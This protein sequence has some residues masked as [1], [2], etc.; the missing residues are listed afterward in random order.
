MGFGKNRVQYGDFYWSFFRFDRF[1]TYYYVNGKELAEYTSKFAYKKIEEIE[2]KFEYRLEKRIIFI[3]YNNL[4]DFRQ[5][6]IGLISGD[7]QYN[8]GGVTKINRNKVFIFYEGD[9]KK[10]EDQISSAI[11]EIVLTEMLF[12]NR[13]RDKVANSTLISLPEWYMLGLI[14]YYSKDWNFEIENEIKDAVLAGKFED[15]NHME[16]KDAEIVG[17]SIWHYI[18]KVHGK[19]AIPNIVH[20]T[21]VSKSADSGFLFALG[22]SF[23]DFSYD[24]IEFYNKKFIEDEKNRNKIDKKKSILKKSKKKYVY[25]NV[26]ISPSGNLIAYTTNEMGQYKIYL[27]NTKTQDHKRI[28]KK[29]HRLNQITDYS[30][31][32][33]SWHPSGDVLAIILEEHGEIWFMYYFVSTD[34]Y[35]TNKLIYFDKIVDFSYSKNGQKFVFSAVVKGQT[36]IF[37]HNLKDHTN[38]RITNDIADDLYPRFAGDGRQIVFS[39]N[40]DSDTL[41]NKVKKRGE[42]LKGIKQPKLQK[43]LD[44]FVYDYSKPF[45]LIRITNTPNINEKEAFEI[46][47]RKFLYLSDKNGI[48]NRRIANFDSTILAIDTMIHYRYVSSNF[49]M[50]NYPRNIKEHDIS[51]ELYAEIVKINGSDKIFTRPLLKEENHFNK[52]VKNTE[53]R[54]LK[55]EKFEKI[56]NI[57]NIKKN[58]KNQ[59]KNFE[60]NSDNKINLDSLILDIRDYTFEMEKNGKNISFIFDSLTRLG[61]IRKYKLPKHQIYETSFYTNKIVNQIDFSFLNFS[62]QTFT[63]GAVYFNP[64]GNVLLKIG[65][66]DLFE[67]YRLTGGVR[68]SGNFDSNEYLISLED[69]KKRIDKNYIFHRQTF[70]SSNENT[71][72]KV[73]THELFYIL[74]YP[75]DQVKSLRGTLSLRNDKMVR[76]S[77]DI[78]NLN[79]DDKYKNW[80]GI[81]LEY[82]FDNII[83]KS[84]NIY[85]GLR[86]KIFAEA[87]KELPNKI[88]KN[89]FEKKGN[90]FVVGGDFRHYQKIHRDIIFASRFAFSGSFG[91]S[92]LI[93]YLGSV[94]NWINLSAAVP[95]FNNSVEIDYS[96]NY[97]YQTLGTNM[98]GFSQNIRN[99]SNFAVINTEFRIP[100]IRYFAKRPINSS[101]LY[102]L[103]IIAFGDLGGAWTGL[104]PWTSENAYDNQTLIVDPITVIVDNDR[105]PIVGGFGFGFRS[106]LLGY[107]VRT[108]W[109]WGVENAMILPHIFYLSLS[110]DF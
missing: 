70:L 81:K 27:Y 29:E 18:E 86:F 40:R 100:I 39:S 74:K 59:K 42:R 61:N 96:K 44:I 72:E 14:A 55:N 50:S 57:E 89:F 68:F 17:F 65:V 95:T 93:F 37:V 108:D 63:G 26:K 8:I 83:H 87:Y 71:V 47:E 23:Y 103:Q 2:N 60:S 16:G 80:S 54:I 5:S 10:F 110:L 21:R 99:G 34:E 3:I 32:L 52:N 19:E 38:T 84:L 62:Y 53:Q 77:T 85:N 12:G 9:H 79:E 22:M 25:Q 30:Y 91:S 105:N 76:L 11:T 88:N 107:F 1:D 97:A 101:F 64:G 33:L 46:S 24:W 31:P 48:V 28:L 69:L 104:S 109:A 56:R 73:F 90:L 13:I 67:D 41:Y 35:E 7:D 45:S 20:L 58:A 15:F 51:N 92:P 82:I 75:F 106:K 94:D 78:L 43:E 36:D 4:T 98:R 102:N 49:P 66:N 6:N